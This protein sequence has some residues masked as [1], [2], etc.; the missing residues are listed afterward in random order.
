MNCRD[1]GSYYKCPCFL[2]VYV[3][4]LLR[5][6]G[7]MPGQS[8]ELRQNVTWTY[9]YVLAKGRGAAIAP[10]AVNHQYS[11]FFAAV[12]FGVAAVMFYVA[13]RR[14]LFPSNPPIPNAA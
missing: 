2:A 8:L 12:A 7:I 6:L 10:L 9:G 14:R 11:I 3:S 5:R 4:A 13:Q 1:S